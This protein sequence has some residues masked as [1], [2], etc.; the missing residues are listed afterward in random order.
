MKDEVIICPT[1]VSMA[2]SEFTFT[3][4]ELSYLYNVLTKKFTLSDPK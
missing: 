2:K 3:I 4:S 1:P